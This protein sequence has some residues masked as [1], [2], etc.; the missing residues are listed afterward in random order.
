MVSEVT[1]AV[2]DPGWEK[3]SLGRWG[4]KSRLLGEASLLPPLRPLT[5]P[6][7]L[8]AQ[9]L[10][11]GACLGAVGGTQTLGPVL[12]VIRAGLGSRGGGASTPSA[13]P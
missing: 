11:T 1:G 13:A 9:G 4:G 10:C 6:S 2:R 8:P 12:W 5:L 7:A 3:G